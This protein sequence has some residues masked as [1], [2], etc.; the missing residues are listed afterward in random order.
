M[1]SG[2]AGRQRQSTVEL[3]R[4]A[5]AELRRCSEARQRV[6]NAHRFLQDRQTMNARPVLLI[7]T[8]AE[9]CARVCRFL[10]PHGIAVVT[11]ENVHTATA[12]LLQMEKPS[13]LLMDHAVRWENRSALTLLRQHATLSDVP[14]GYMKKSAALD[15]LLLMLTPTAARNQHCAA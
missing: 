1:T 10:E 15:A 6:K 13:A 5:L 14:V 8:D 4:G 3:G 11:A 12:H 9:W 7:A 2:R